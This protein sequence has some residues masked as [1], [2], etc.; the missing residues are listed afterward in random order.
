[1]ERIPV[2]FKKDK[3]IEGAGREREAF[4]TLRHMQ[5]GVLLSRTSQDRRFCKKK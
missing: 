3:G 5:T 4:T 2:M 1:M